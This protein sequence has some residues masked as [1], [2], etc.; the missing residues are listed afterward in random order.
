MKKGTKCIFPSLALLARYLYDDVIRLF[1]ASLP[2]NWRLTCMLAT[3]LKLLL[4]LSCLHILSSLFDFFVQRL[5]F[6]HN[7]VWNVPATNYLNRTFLLVHYPFFQHF[8]T[9]SQEGSPSLYLHPGSTQTLVLLC[10]SAISHQS[11]VQRRLVV[12]LFYGPLI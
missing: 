11:Y 6:A 3:T 7:I 5:W 8:K 2:Q 10:I 1:R 4:E 12:L 9:C